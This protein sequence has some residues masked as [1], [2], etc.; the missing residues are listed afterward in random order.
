MNILSN[1]IDVL[2]EMRKNDGELE[3]FIIIISIEIIK[4]QIVEIKIVNNGFN[5]SKEN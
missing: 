3:Q 5:I 2:E 1:V 4:N